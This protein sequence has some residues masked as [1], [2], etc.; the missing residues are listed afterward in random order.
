MSNTAATYP[1]TPLLVGA[2]PSDATLGSSLCSTGAPS[3]CGDVMAAIR[4]GEAQM[5]RH[6]I[7]VCVAK[8]RGSVGHRF[9]SHSDVSGLRSGGME[10]GREADR[11]VEAGR[12]PAYS[13]VVGRK[14]RGLGTGDRSRAAGCARRSKAG[15]IGDRTLLRS[16][17]S[18][19]VGGGVRDVEPERMTTLELVAVV[20]VNVVVRD[21]RRKRELEKR[22]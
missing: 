3:G 5:G 21:R 1:L 8:A 2:A 12:R 19:W 6:H 18:L 20:A 22:R 10:N 7:K 15:A 17:V 16:Q 9:I 14:G 11:L 4:D 13:A